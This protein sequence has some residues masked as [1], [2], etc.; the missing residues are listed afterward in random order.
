MSREEKVA[1]FLEYFEGKEFKQKE[2]ILSKSEKIID[3][4]KFINYHVKI[5][6]HNHKKRFCK[7]CILALF[8]IKKQLEK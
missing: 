7:P 3:L 4:Q 2:M 5:I 1:K 8:Q 6:K